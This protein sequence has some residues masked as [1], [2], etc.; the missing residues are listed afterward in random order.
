MKMD[1]V[2]YHFEHLDAIGFGWLQGVEGTLLLYT[3]DEFG[4]QYLGVPVTLEEQIAFETSKLSVRSL[5]T[6]PHVYLIAAD[7]TF[8]VI[9]GS[10]LEN[11][12]KEGV[13]L[14]P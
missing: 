3:L 12:P 5:L 1:R 14:Y 6:R 11:L 2:L 4:D 10:T 13:F 8:Q 9:D 7:R